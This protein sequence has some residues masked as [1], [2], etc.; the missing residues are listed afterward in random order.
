MESLESYS[1]NNPPSPSIKMCYI[2]LSIGIFLITD[3]LSEQIVGRWGG[4][5][6]YKVKKERHVNF[7]PGIGLT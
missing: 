6:L 4:G 5:V 1:Q 3:S 2:L 7:K